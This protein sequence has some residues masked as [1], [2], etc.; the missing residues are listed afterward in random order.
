MTTLATNVDHDHVRTKEKTY[1]SNPAHEQFSE[2]QGF[3]GRAALLPC[4]FHR[5]LPEAHLPRKFNSHLYR[6][7]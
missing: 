2:S 3:L 6:S 1:H 4:L 5:H 7:N